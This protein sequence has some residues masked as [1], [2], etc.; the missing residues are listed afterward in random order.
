MRADIEIDK[1]AVDDGAGGGRG[2]GNRSQIYSQSHGRRAWRGE[3]EGGEFRAAVNVFSPFSRGA[4][5]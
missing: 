2:G 3:G 4:G 1:F 5:L